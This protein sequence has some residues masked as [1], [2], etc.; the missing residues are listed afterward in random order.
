MR[1]RCEEDEAGHSVGMLQREAR[2]NRASEGMGDDDRTVDADCLH[3]RSDSIGLSAWQV[4]LRPAALGITMARPV[5]EEQF[6]L[7]LQG[8]SKGEILV[9]QVA[10]RAMQEDHRR[11]R[12]SCIGRLQV[13][14]VHSVAADIVEFPDGRVARLDLARLQLGE[15]GKSAKDQQQNAEKINH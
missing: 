8:A 6:R 13:Q 2:R 15:N 14:R 11:Q 5:D 12:R 10:A 9:L 3:Q 7:A 4:V 1:G